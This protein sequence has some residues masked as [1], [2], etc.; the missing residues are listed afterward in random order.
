M[1]F[2]GQNLL[3][4]P[5]YPGYADDGLKISCKLVYSGGVSAMRSEV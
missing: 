1:N 4:L 3:V 2:Y 5:Q